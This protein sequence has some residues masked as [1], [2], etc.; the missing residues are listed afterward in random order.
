MKVGT[1]VGRNTISLT[2]EEIKSITDKVIPY[3]N[4]L[5]KSLPIKFK[6]EIKENKSYDDERILD[7]YFNVKGKHTFIDEDKMKFVPTDIHIA[8]R[9]QIGYDEQVYGRF[10]EWKDGFVAPSHMSS[11]SGK[12]DLYGYYRRFRGKSIHHASLTNNPYQYGTELNDINFYGCLN[13]IFKFIFYSTEIKEKLLK[14]KPK[15]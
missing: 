11:Y 14:D 9:K 15:C 2:D 8:I 10:Y 7:I 12:I 4:D 13:T 5:F 3:A 6:I 1:F